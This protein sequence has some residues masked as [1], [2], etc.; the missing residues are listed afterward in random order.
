VSDA[1]LDETLLHRYFDGELPASQVAAARAHLDACETCAKEHRALVR[2][3]EM[4]SVA[5]V[6][7]A[8]ELDANALFGRIEQGVRAEQTPPLWERVRVWWGEFIEH[9]TEVWMPLGA[10]LA[11]AAVIAVVAI[12]GGSPET[13]A[14]PSASQTPAVAPAP[15]ARA[16]KPRPKVMLA[17]SEVVQVDFGENAGTVFEIALAEGVSTPVVWIN[18]ELEE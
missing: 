16:P 13:G 4:I 18:D 2:L 6:D 10:G 12:R 1:H 14:G 3:R 5:A 11:A 8:T 7:I 9:H 15:V 17:N